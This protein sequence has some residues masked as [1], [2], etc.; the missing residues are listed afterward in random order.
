M[1]ARNSN[2][3]IWCYKLFDR[4]DCGFS[5]TVSGAPMNNYY[6]NLE[7]LDE[8]LIRIHVWQDKKMQRIFKK[9]ERRLRRE[10][11]QINR[12]VTEGIN[13]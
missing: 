12:D 3:A 7:H 13:A 10:F 4:H 5:N 2:V 11:K 9:T 1:K 8:Q 6:K